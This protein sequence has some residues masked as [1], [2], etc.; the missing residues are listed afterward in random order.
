MRDLFALDRHFE[1]IAMPDADV[2]I[3]HGIEMP[4]PYGLMLQRLG[5]QTKWRQESVRVYGKEHQQPRLEH[6]AD[7]VNRGIRKME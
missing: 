6:R 2:S 3:L 7:F 4:L 1:P 5:E